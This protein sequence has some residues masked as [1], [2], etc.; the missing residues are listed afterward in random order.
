MDGQKVLGF[1][2]TQGMNLLRGLVVLAV[3]CFLVHWLMKLIER[4][5]KY[6]R[7]EATLKGFLGKLLKLMLYVVVILT[8]AN[9][10]GIPMTSV[11]TLLASAGVAISLAM[12]GALSNLVGGVTLLMLKPIAVGDFVSVNGIDGTVKGIGA[13]YT[14][15]TTPD[16]RHV[17]MPNSSMVNTSI[18]N[19]SREGTRR[20][21]LTFPIGYDADIGKVREI[22]LGLAENCPTVM[23]DPAPIA[24]MTAFSDS[25]VSIVLRLWCRSGD[26]LTTMY[27]L[28]ENGK[29]ALETA[30]IV[31]PFPQMDVHLK[32]DKEAF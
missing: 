6:V 25:S 18:V 12:Q 9:I 19:Y 22:L 23:S 7:I 20:M 4:S 27:S 30:G 3:G 8:T 17:F 21:D 24:V 1:I 5:E 31:I 2:E 10:I 13:F 32:H 14:D 16:N 26:Y 28:Q 11:I 29:K 15:M